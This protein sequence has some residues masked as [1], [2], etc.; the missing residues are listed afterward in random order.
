MQ[1]EKNSE[2]HLRPRF[3][4]DFDDSQEHILQKFKSNLAEGDCKYCSKIVDGHIVIDVPKEDDHFWSPQLQIEIEKAEDEKSTVKGLFGP[5]PTVWTLFMFIHFA[6]GTAFI[7]FSIM[8][9][10]QYMLKKDNTFALT[11]IVVIPVIWVL[12][13]FFGRIGRRAGHKQME[14]LHHFVEKTL[15]KKMV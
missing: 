3:K 12:M 4:I 1:E 14:E 10:V 11:M 2:I 9:Y 8:G 6:L 5:K 15:E 13:Y 7:A